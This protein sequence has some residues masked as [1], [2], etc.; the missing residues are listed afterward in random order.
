MK[1]VLFY[2]SIFLFLNS[3]NLLAIDTK[4]EE[5][6][7]YDFD[8]KEILFQKNANTKT[9]PASM[10]KIMTIYIAFDRIKN[11]NLSISN[12]CRVSPRAYKMGGSRTFLEIDD[13]VTIDSLLKGIIVQSGNDASIALAECLAGTEIDFAAI[14]K[15]PYSL[16]TVGNA[17]SIKELFQKSPVD[18]DLNIGV[19]VNKAPSSEEVVSIFE[20]QKEP[21]VDLAQLQ[22][23]IEY[24]PM[25]RKAR[26]QGKVIVSVLI[27]KTGKS[28]KCEIIHSDN[29]ML[30]EAAINAVLKAS[31]TPA[32]QNGYPVN[33]KVT[34]PIVF[35]LK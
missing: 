8:T 17:E 5:A 18:V 3:N 30:D 13:T 33:C 1:K 27:N 31:F 6:I 2:L 16:S 19:K 10:T 24:P 32:I 28:Q 26:I 20:V 7:V 23:L 21:T 14:D 4:A 25:A 22:G 29:S 12:E 34:I 35:K 11:T 9:I 15:L